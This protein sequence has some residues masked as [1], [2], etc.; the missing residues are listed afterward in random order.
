MFQ[1]L[2]YPIQNKFLDTVN[3]LCGRIPQVFLK[4]IEKA[5]KT[6]F[7]A[8]VVRHVRPHKWLR[9]ESWT[10]YGLWAA[11]G[12]VEANWRLCGLVVLDTM[13]LLEWVTLQDNGLRWFGGMNR[14]C[15]AKVFP[16]PLTGV[17]YFTTLQCQAL[18]CFIRV[19]Q[20]KGVWLSPLVNTF[21]K[22]I[23]AHSSHNAEHSLN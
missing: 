4:Q 8:N 18:M 12:Y 14:Q 13:N 1:S 15:L 7:E 21:S 9:L 17:S 19:D 10:F 22:Q 2:F 20:H 3:T 11:M 23:F 16:P 5:M 6:V